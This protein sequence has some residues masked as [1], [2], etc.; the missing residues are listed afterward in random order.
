MVAAGEAARGEGMVKVAVKAKAAVMKALKNS[1]IIWATKIRARCAAHLAIPER[2]CTASSIGDA[3]DLR[4]CLPRIC[5]ADGA[6][7]LRSPRTLRGVTNFS[8]P[9]LRSHMA[10]FA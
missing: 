10:S 1:R 2:G 5:A 8:V 4:I 6:F 3:T 9:V 7:T